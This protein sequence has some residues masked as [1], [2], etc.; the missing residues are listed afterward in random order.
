M[1]LYKFVNQCEDLVIIIPTNYVVQTITNQE[2]GWWP[3]KRQN[4]DNEINYS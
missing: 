1:E 4:N 3:Q 2:N